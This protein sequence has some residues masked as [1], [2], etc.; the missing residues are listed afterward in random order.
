M[1]RT[2]SRPV[3]VSGT[4]LHSGAPARVT[5]RP[6]APGTGIAFLRADLPG[7]P[8]IPALWDRVAQGPLAT[9]LVE[10]AA[11]VS[12]VEHLM[13]A[14]AGSGVHN[15]LVELRGPEVPILDGSSAPWLRA[16]LDAGVA[17]QDAPLRALRVREAVEVRDGEAL[18]RLEPAPAPSLRFVIDF[19]DAAIGHQEMELALANGAFVRELANSRTFCRLGDVEAMRARGLALGGTFS[20][21]VVVDGARVLT[22]GGLRHPDEAVRHK[23][24]DAVGDLGLAGGPVV[25]R[26]LGLRAGHALT[27]RLLRA[28]FARPSAWEWVEAD[29]AL[30]ALL[31]GAGVG[32]EDL[33]A[34]PA[35]A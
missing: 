22:P 3:S 25:G 1:Q 18:A 4:G 5:L 11:S 14:F 16:I 10:G 34:L 2:L 27:N 20:N 17:G 19:P 32:P 21:A 30:E 35:V 31:P 29:A 8:R 12:T 7:R 15:A 23:M 6:A 9:R 26:F 24:L 33:L 28:L 13:A